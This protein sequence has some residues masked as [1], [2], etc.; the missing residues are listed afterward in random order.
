MDFDEVTRSLRQF[1]DSAPGAVILLALGF[2]LFVLLVVDTW[3]HKH[4][5]NRPPQ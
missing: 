2:A 1:W 4:R 3:R 5:R